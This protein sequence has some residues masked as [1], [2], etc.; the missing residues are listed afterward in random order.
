MGGGGGRE[1]KQSEGETALANPSRA[2]P[3]FVET[4][5]LE[6]VRE[7]NCSCFRIFFLGRVSARTMILHSERQ[8]THQRSAA[9]RR[10]KTLHPRGDNQNK[11]NIPRDGNLQPNTP[12]PPPGCRRR[13]AVVSYS[14]PT[15]CP[16]R[17]FPSRPSSHTC[18][19]FVRPLFY[20][21]P[22]HSASPRL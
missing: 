11:G 19:T 22:L 2:A 6:L 1:A 17:G 10:Q 7:K 8:R 18:P 13:C 12:F 14:R 4:N 16:T 3:A 15:Y 9:H 5:Y 21:P 20:P